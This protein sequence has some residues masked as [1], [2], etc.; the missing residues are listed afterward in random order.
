MLFPRPDAPATSQME[1]DVSKIEAGVAKAY[2][3]GKVPV[4]FL[5]D[6]DGT[7]RLIDI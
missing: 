6:K 3:K 2:Q 7:L 4:G 5:M 1:R